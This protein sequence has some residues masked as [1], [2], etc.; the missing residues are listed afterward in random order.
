MTQD[1]FSQYLSWHFFEAPRNILKAWRNF[2]R[3]NFNYFSIPLLFKTFFSHWRRY[4]WIYPKGFDI[5][6]Y[7][8]VFFSNLISRTLGTILR[9]F[10]IIIGSLVEVFIIF[11]GIII[12]LGWLI[13][14][15]FLILGIY[16]G[17]RILL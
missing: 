11:V 8:E 1:I 12:F 9:F 14:P 15:I 13:M 3:F 2:L 4:R 16:H 7:F 10:L 5:G 6:K 17:F